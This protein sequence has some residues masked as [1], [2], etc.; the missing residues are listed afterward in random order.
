MTPAELGDAVRSCVA[1]AVAS[2][3]LAVEPPAAVTVER[4]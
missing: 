1:A 4:P 2:G 3:D